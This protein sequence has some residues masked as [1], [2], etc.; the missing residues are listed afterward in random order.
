VTLVLEDAP[1]LV[2]APAAV[3]LVRPRRRAVRPFPTPLTDMGL[4][5]LSDHLEDASAEE[6]VAWAAAM[7][8]RRLTIAASMTDA[9]L[10]DVAARVS[11]GIEVIFVDT[12][13]HF[14]ETLATAE[15][16]RDRYPIQ[17]RVVWPEVVPDD[18]W[19]TDPDRCCQLRK[20]APMERAL[21]GRVAWLSGLRRADSVSRA[22]APV[23]QRDRRGLVK[24]NPLVR[25][26]DEEVARYIA[27]HDVPVNPLVAQGYASVGC[28]PCTRAIGEGEDGRAGRWDGSDKTECGLH[29]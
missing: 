9:V 8:G 4:R 14:Q 7:F 29:L 16:I 25:W 21:R 15:R 22:L 20:V 27:E 28:W 12:Q 11:P 23:V 1:A 19:R 10:I 17:L 3:A 2:A 18:L 13:Y 5:Q 6:I 26:T 24:V